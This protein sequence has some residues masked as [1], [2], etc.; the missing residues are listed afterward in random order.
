MKKEND[1]PINSATIQ[2]LLIS[3]FFK[4]FS[5]ERDTIV[6]TGI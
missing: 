2:F 5:V 4:I 6:L 1:F 3:D